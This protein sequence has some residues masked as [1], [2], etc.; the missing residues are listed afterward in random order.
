MIMLW[1]DRF[2]P[3][4]FAAYRRFVQTFEGDGTEAFGYIGLDHGSRKI[5]SAFKGS[6]TLRDWVRYRRPGLALL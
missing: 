6:S 4:K 5:V 3:S 2:L 1:I